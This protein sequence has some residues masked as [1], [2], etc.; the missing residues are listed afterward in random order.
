M[1][2]D[3]C[4]ISQGSQ[5]EADGT[6]KWNLRHVNEGVSSIQ[7]NNPQS[8]VKHPK[9]GNSGEPLIPVDLRGWGKG[10]HSKE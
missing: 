3:N 8:M 5:Q 10:A 2:E 6:F 7:G 4:I 1:L 9:A